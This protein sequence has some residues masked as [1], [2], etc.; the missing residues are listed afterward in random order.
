M[1]RILFITVIG[2]TV[3]HECKSGFKVVLW[4]SLKVDHFMLMRR[5]MVFVWLA[6]RL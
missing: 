2:D 6:T 1:A 3:I 4:P 5:C